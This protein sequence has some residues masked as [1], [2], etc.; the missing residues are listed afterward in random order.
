MHQYRKDWEDMAMQ[1][2]SQAAFFGSSFYDVGS[3]YLVS[4]QFINGAAYI[5][6]VLSQTLLEEYHKRYVTKTEPMNCTLIGQSNYTAIG[7]NGSN[8]E[9]FL[10]YS[11]VEKDIIWGSLVSAFIFMPGVLFWSLLAYQIRRSKLLSTLFLTIALI[12]LIPLF[13]FILLLVKFVAI[14]NDGPQ[15]THLKTMVSLC[16][17]QIESFLQLGLQVYIILYRSDRRPSI[18]VYHLT[19]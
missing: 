9:E 13:P 19:F 14:F 3:D 5:K 10:R 12:P 4:E 2:F 18:G 17:G 11:C 15:L 8:S 16:E 7:L 1:F 6:D